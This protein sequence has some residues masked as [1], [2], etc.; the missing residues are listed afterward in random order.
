[1]DNAGK[2]NLKNYL[3]E[4]PNFIPLFIYQFFMMLSSPILLDMG[5]Y[6]NTSPE[7]MNI[8]ITFFII[9]VVSGFAANFFLNKHLKGNTLMIWAH[10]LVLPALVGL[11][12]A[13]SL[14]LFYILYFI[15]AFFIGIIFLNANI[16]IFEGKV[17]N[18]DSI[19][20]LGHSFFALGALTSPF[21]SSAIVSRQINWKFIYLAVIFF[22]L[23]SLI[24]NIYKN[25][26]SDISRGL[27]TENKTFY[28]KELFQN[29]NKFIYM[30]MT[31]ILQFFYVMSEVTIFS[32]APTF[33][34]IEKLFNIYEASLVV[35][36]FWAGIL[37]G[38]LLV[39]FLSYKFRAG[40]LLISLSI[41]SIAG[42]FL[43]IFPVSR[44]I[45]FIGATITGLGFSG[46]PPL[47]ISSAGRIFST[48]KD[49]A[50]T[51]FFSIGTVGASFIPFII[52]ALAGHNLFLSMIIAI[53]LMVIVA[54]LAIIRK[55]YRKTLN[56]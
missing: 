39:S 51:I 44:G 25:K 27:E 31:I 6:F 13:T 12:L 3:M 43:I 5:N 40:I 23:I 15:S 24:F 10:V 9:G 30:I 54:I 2:T 11:I 50:L 49:L 17:K 38:R 41:I 34:R 56:I 8:I 36:L 26:K 46:I 53:I 37:A 33:F 20:N 28:T 32:W 52:R 42:L 29:K 4:F 48:A 22:V 21:F 14:S 1:M 35:S 16:S 45:N 18:K 55:Y 19:V 7:K 47:L